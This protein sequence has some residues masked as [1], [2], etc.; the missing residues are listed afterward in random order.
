M[1]YNEAEV[2]A[3]CK[4]YGIETVKKEGAP[5]YQDEEMEDGFSYSDMMHEPCKFMDDGIFISSSFINM[6]LSVYGEHRSYNRI[7]AGNSDRIEYDGNMD[8]NDKVTS[9]ISNNNENKYAA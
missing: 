2:L 1:L 8:E 6:S 5:L 9:S 7:L 4:K 3:I